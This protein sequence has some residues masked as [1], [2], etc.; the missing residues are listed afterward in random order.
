VIKLRKMKLAGHK[1]HLEEKRNACR[2]LIGRHKKRDC[3]EDLGLYMRMI[4]NGS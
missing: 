2:V 4:L 1:A 3:S